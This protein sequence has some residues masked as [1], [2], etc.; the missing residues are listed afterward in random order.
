MIDS[1]LHALRENP[2][3]AIF[4]S[5]ALGTWIGK[6][7]F[8]KFHL[9]TVAGSLLMGLIIGQIDIEIPAM[10]KAVFCALLI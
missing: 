4:L 10:L 9:G 7:K 3:V 6:V 2:E 8:G 1:V 5:I